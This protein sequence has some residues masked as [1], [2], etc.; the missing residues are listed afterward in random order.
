M[1]LLL[2][3]P[4]LIRAACPRRHRSRHARK[5]RG[6]ASNLGSKR[7]AEHNGSPQSFRRMSYIDIVFDAPP[8]PGRR[9]GFI[10]VED[11]QGYSIIAGNWV[12][13]SDGTWALRILMP[14]NDKDENFRAGLPRSMEGEGLRIVPAYTEAG[15]FGEANVV[16]ITDGE[17]TALYV[18]LSPTRAKGG[19]GL[20]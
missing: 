1:M 13:R 18:P 4:P 8:G 15:Y 17:R 11:T 12:E 10:E 20:S 16:T 6:G 5:N 14:G 2:F 7:L 9:P 3:D 19:S